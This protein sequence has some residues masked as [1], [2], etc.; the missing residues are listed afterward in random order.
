[1]NEKQS[2]SNTPT[3]ETQPHLADVIG[4]LYELWER[5]K[6]NRIPSI[7]VMIKQLQIAVKQ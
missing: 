6:R 2:H 7:D 5:L 1:M 3:K 4:S